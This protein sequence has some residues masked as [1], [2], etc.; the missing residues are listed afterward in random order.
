M[1]D[2][3]N[4]GGYPV[5]DWDRWARATDAV[6]PSLRWQRYETVEQAGWSEQALAEAKR[7]SEKIGSAA[8]MVVFNGAVLA[9]WGQIERRFMCHS[10]RK[11]LLSALYGQAVSQGC[12]DLDEALGSVSIDD[13]PPLTEIEKTARI[14][15]LLK[16]RSCVYL[17]AAY[18][19]QNMRESRP[20]RGSHV[21][22]SHWYYNNWDF[23]VLGTVYNLKTGGDVFEAF[24]RQLAKPMA[25]Q[26]FLPRHG[27]YHLEPQNSTHPAYPFRMSARDLARFGLLYL[28]EGEWQGRQLIPSAWVHESTR[29]YS[30]GPRYGGYGYLWW[31]E[32]DAIGKLGA[33]YAAGVGHRIYVI[34]RAQLVIVH[35]ADTYRNWRRPIP[36]EDLRRLVDNILRARTGPPLAQPKLI[37]MPETPRSSGGNVLTEAEMK[38]LCG[39]YRWNR[40]PL[41]IRRDKAR[42]EINSPRHGRFYLTPRSPSEFVIED[43]EHRVEFDSDEAGKATG[44]RFWNPS[45]TMPRYP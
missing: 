34:P 41:I 7:F 33:Y 38:A 40:G 11:S 43:M 17:P 32:G 37:D 14:S 3:S 8:V 28:R 44:L 4:T 24:D 22:G 6:Y 1:G 31:I 16:S 29:T 36:D 10:I 15:D 9:H 2:V 13:D 21:P 23:N 19:S 27:Y 5:E 26:D 45:E 20:A 25:M 39:E 12:I 30:E 42:L 35:R 18:E